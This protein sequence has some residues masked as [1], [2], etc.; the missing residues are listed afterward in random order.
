MAVKV[1]AVPCLE[2]NYLW[3]LRDGPTGAVAICDPGE[4]APAIAAVEAAGGKLD[5]IL[6]THHHGDH[7]DGVAE[8]KARFPEARIIGGKPD[9]HRLPKLDLAVDEGDTVHFGAAEAKVMHLPGHTTG[10]I[11]FHFAADHFLLCGDVVFALGCGRPLE[12]GGMEALFKS[13]QRLAK[14]P[15]DTRFCCGHE[16]TEANA[17]FALT[18]EPGNKALRAEAEAASA[19][20]AAGRPTVPTTL[21]QEL[22]ANPYFRARDLAEFTA[23]REAKNHFRG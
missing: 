21:A 9:A 15:P 11:A 7:I 17:R 20:R 3:L 4:A 14:L 19:L 13:F 10:H 16:Y 23:R 5:A 18:I 1:E 6:L 8:L 22:V 12:P 2:D